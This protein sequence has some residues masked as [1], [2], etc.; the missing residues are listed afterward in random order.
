MYRTYT[1]AQLHTWLHYT[2]ICS[3]MFTVSSH[4]GR[5]QQEYIYSWCGSV[6]YLD[7]FTNTTSAGCVCHY[8]A[9]H[10]RSLLSYRLRQEVCAL[11]HVPV[12]GIPSYVF[13]RCM[14]MLLGELVA[15]AFS[16]KIT[17]A[18]VPTHGVMSNILSI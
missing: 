12:E 17:L 15:H 8:Y 2:Y 1:H 4:T 10:P 9:F 13:R 6:Q 7:P 18:A 11:K 5:Y 14:C 3:I 16:T